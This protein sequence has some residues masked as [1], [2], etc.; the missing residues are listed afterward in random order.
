MNTAFK[1]ALLMDKSRLQEIYDLRVIAYEN[2]SKFSYVNKRLFPD[3]W[4]DELDKLDTT[5]HWIIEVDNIVIASARLAI[6]DYIKDTHVDF[7]KF[8]LPSGRPFAYWSRLV[9]HPDYRKTSA[10]MMLDAVRNR[11]LIDHKNIKFALCCVT[12]ERSKAVI[13]QGFK[14]MGECNYNWGQEKTIAQSQ[15]MYLYQNNP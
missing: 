12:E 13:R 11:Y 3:G 10:M 5:L 7:D 6:L 14:Y 1:P 4:F 15:L 9:V 8:E 2:S